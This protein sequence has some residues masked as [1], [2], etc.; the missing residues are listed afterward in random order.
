MQSEVIQ[1]TKDKEKRTFDIIRLL[2]LHSLVNGQRTLNQL[3]NDSGINWKTV[4]N[5]IIYLLGR[6][7]VTEVYFSKYVKIVEITQKGKEFLQS[8]NISA[9]VEV[10]V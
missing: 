7:F 8:K 2:I 4:D 1:A 3:S 5:H 6:G 10:Q 9:K